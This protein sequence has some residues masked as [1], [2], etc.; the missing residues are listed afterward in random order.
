MWLA[1][2]EAGKTLANALGEVREAVDFCRYYASQLREPGFDADGNA[3]GVVA[4]ISPWN[5][6]IAIFIGQ[7][8][9]ALAAGNSV[10]AKPAEQTPL[11]AARA[12][13]LLH[14]AGV[15]HPALQLLPG[16]GRIGALLCADARVRGVLFTGSTEVAKLIDRQLA[17]RTVDEEI[18]LVA[19]TGGINA[20][21]VDS[22]ALPEQVVADV[23]ASSF[24]SAGQRCSALR[25]LCL[26]KDIAGRVRAMLEGALRQLAVGDPARLSTDVGPIID[27]EARARLEAHVERMRTIHHAARCA[28]PAGS[29]AGNFFAPA[30]ISIDSLAQLDREVFGPVLHVLRYRRVE[31]G[32]LIDAINATG[33]GLTFG[34]H[35]RIDETIDFV[36]D[37]IRA[38]NLYVNR[39]MIGAVV[40]VQPFGGL[41]R[42]GTGPKAGGPL[43]LKRLRR[44]ARA[45][46]L[47]AAGEAMLPPAFSEL[48]RWA[49][50]SGNADLSDCCDSLA[51][52]APLGRMLALPGPTGESN[53]LRLIPRGQVLCVA[54]ET[55]ELLRQLAHA[56]VAGNRAVL[57]AAGA[58]GLLA[59]LPAVVRQ[60]ASATNEAARAAADVVLCPPAKAAA[61]RRL[62]AERDGPRV[63]VVTPVADGA[64][65]PIDALVFEQTITVNTAA[66]GG[67]AGL[68]T[69]DPE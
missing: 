61:L 29:A 49:Q 1:V 52:A 60:Q 37:R 22:S 24:D 34:V 48:R 41:G 18:V 67:N 63:R 19:E 57:C 38:G 51:R 40:G 5:F 14:E 4:C 17:A 50:A 10:I 53:R 26:Q 43:M 11:V 7:V 45:G 12:V 54:D 31:L 21:V 36:A 33:Y 30:L 47:P 66:A 35:S 6:P 68:M 44:G 62:L 27:A 2:H 39:N 56:L 23:L 65:Y 3:L 69:L 58:G 25:V 64:A 46:H 13:Q 55:P 42:S 28:L 32:E 9:A 15:P 20:M 59:P 8:S 16:D